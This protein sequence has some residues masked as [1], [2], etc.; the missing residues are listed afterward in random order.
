MSA[1]IN[2]FDFKTVAGRYDAGRPYFH[3]HVVA[4]IRSHL[5][6]NGKLSRAL[7]VGCGTGLSSKALLEIASKVDAIDASSE[8]L[9][10]AFPDPRIRYHHQRAEDIDY[11][12]ESFDL[13]AVS[14]VIHWT[15]QDRLFANIRR[16]LKEDGCLVV[17]D[18]FFLWKTEGQEDFSLWFRENYLTKFPPPHRG[19]FSITDASLVACGFKLANQEEYLSPLSYSCDQ[20]VTYLITESNVC[21]A[22]DAQGVSIDVAKDWLRNQTER[23]FG[24]SGKRTFQFGGP[25]YYLRKAGD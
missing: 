13:A 6:V 18:N 20:L 22:C 14:K 19:S 8:M 15:D 25:I 21:A 10:R 7:D 5:G 3:S 2:P 12:N 16:C 17:Y 11:P 23:F 9:A 1:F 24:E 4:R